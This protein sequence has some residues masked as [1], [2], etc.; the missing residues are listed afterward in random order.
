M[1]SRKS[2]AQMAGLTGGGAYL[3]TAPLGSGPRGPVASGPAARIRQLG[4][5]REWIRTSPEVPGAARE[6]VARSD[7]VCNRGRVASWQEFVSAEPEMARQVAAA[8]AVGKHCTLATVRADGAPRISGTEIEFDGPDVFLGMMVGSRKGQDVRRDPRVAVHSPTVDPV[9]PS[10]WVGEAKFSGQVI[11]VPAPQG[12]P[13]GGE[14]FRVELTSV[15][16]TGLTDDARSL[17]IQLWRPDRGHQVMT[18]A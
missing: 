9:T 10:E 5:E 17:R 12:H 11:A 4:P 2:P 15:V 3:L 16:F 7:R 8:F 6:R 13:A 14:R 1:G 18:R